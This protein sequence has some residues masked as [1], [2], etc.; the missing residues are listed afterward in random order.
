MM[1]D[2]LAKR[3]IAL[4][5]FGLEGRSM[6]KVLH[7]SAFPF[8]VIDDHRIA[9]LEQVKRE[10]GRSVEVVLPK[11]ITR[12]LFDVIIV[13]PGVSWYRPELVK[14]RDEGIEVTSPASLWLED[15][16][17]RRIL[18]ITGTKGKSTTASLAAVILRS[19]G[20]TVALGGNIGVPVTNFYREP[21]HD[22]YVIEFSSHQTTGL[23]NSPEA[24]VLTSLAPDHLTWHG[25]VEQYYHDKLN[26]FRE[27]SSVRAA[28]NGLNAEAVSRTEGLANRIL[29]GRP[30]DPVHADD[31]Y[32]YVHGEK[33][34][35]V[36][37]LHLPGFHNRLNLLGALAG[38]HQLMGA[39][40]VMNDVGP[41]LS[42]F[43]GLP[44]RLCRIAS[45]GG[46]EYYDDALASNALA[47]SAA[48]EVFHGKPLTLI[49]G[50]EDRGIP[51][52]M[53]A[54]SLQ[55]RLQ[56]ATNVVLLPGSERIEAA[57]RRELEASKSFIKLIPVASLQDAVLE[58]ALVTPKGGAVL[59]SPGAPT[60]KK[61]GSYKDRSELFQKAVESLQKRSAS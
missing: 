47:V 51:Y 7:E 46:I 32:G 58:A 43:H 5:G 35:R 44:S 53:F 9:T 8:T 50:G 23:L 25:S 48:L 21:D 6:A 26:L 31:Q 41:K 22:I 30:E 19:L 3:R 2:R 10:Y 27:S 12:A 49:M 16:R 37:D 42:A 1:L 18:G 45:V 34:V 24:A 13:S 36:R 57:I 59:F 11:Q 38:V 28:V 52:D 61:E 39:A 15:Y 29:Y 55:K 20:Y 17:D 60:P 33:V 54:K 40:P 4:F 14:A 56:R